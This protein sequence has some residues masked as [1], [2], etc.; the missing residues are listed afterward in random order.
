MTE[1]EL[2]NSIVQ[3]CRSVSSIY[4]CQILPLPVKLQTCKLL[5][6]A[7]QMNDI[8]WRAMNVADSYE[9]GKELTGALL[10][11]HLVADLRSMRKHMNLGISARRQSV[12][13]MSDKESATSLALRAVLA[14]S[15]SAKSAMVENEFHKDLMMEFRIHSNAMIAASLQRKQDPRIP[16]K[17]ES[18]LMR[19]ILLLK[20]FSFRSRPCSD[21]LVQEGAIDLI[22]SQFTGYP[23]GSAQVQNASL[24]LLV[25]MAGNSVAACLEIIDVKYPSKSRPHNLF[26]QLLEIWE[27]KRSILPLTRLC[28]HVVQALLQIQESRAAILK[29]A[30]VSRMISF[31]ER[32]LKR[33]DSVKFSQTLKFFSDLAAFKDSRS[34]LLH[35]SSFSDLM[36]F[37][38]C[39]RR[40]ENNEMAM[41][42][43]LLFLRNMSFS[44]DMKTYLSSKPEALQLLLDHVYNFTSS[45]KMGLLAS[46]SL[47][48]LL[49]K[50]Q[51]M[52]ACV[53]NLDEANE[54]LLNVEAELACQRDGPEGIEETRSNL[55]HILGTILVGHHEE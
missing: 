24:G 21:A 42:E 33:R 48:I 55:R 5:E 27:S 15:E 39:A 26:A 13:R 22:R 35:H 20:H 52:K 54:R 8:G 12:L 9:E 53:R 25:N 32:V 36:E 30:F 7:L 2:Q 34:F 45:P 49:Y 41:E 37:I 43:V 51:K 16:L 31:L 17:C 4:K 47:W 11:D 46:S 29:S 44:Q 23:K 40:L 38:L 14:C 28:G 50:S 18:Q 3:V 1:E 19:V 10:C 6:I